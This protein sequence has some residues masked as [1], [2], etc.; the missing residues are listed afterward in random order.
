MQYL[1]EYDMY[2]N[3]QTTIFEIIAGLPVKQFFRERMKVGGG[4][5]GVGW[6]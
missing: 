3:I 2:N 6:D 4:G 1:M 5:V